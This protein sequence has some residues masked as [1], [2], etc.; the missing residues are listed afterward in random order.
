VL[1]QP[2]R[3]LHLWTLASLFSSYADSPTR[4]RYTSPDGLYFIPGCSKVCTVLHSICSRVPR[5][6]HLSI[7]QP[8]PQETNQYDNDRR[9]QEW[10]LRIY[11]PSLR[12]LQFERWGFFAS[13]SRSGIVF[14]I[15][16]NSI[17]PAHFDDKIVTGIR[18]RIST[19]ANDGWN[20][21][22]SA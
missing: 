3:Y 6:S 8:P 18:H 9:L 10:R 12:C 13:L 1:V 22:L 7:P 15:C 4:P 16:A 2:L 5:S 19:L 21:E 20:T 17:L 14:D 11:D